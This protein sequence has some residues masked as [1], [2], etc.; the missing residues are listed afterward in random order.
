[1]PQRLKFVVELSVFFYC[2]TA[3]VAG[4]AI[5]NFRI[6]RSLSNRI[7]SERLI[8]IQIESRSFAGP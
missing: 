5:R 6:G 4:A 8:R 1:M 7:E 2:T 3:N